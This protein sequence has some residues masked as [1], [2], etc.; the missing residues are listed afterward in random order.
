M[1]SPTV[2]A[3]ALQTLCGL[4]AGASAPD[5]RIP[6]TLLFNEGWLL[7]LVLAAA[8][9]GCPGL[10]FALQPQARWFSEALLRSAFL[11]RFRGDPLA[12]SST[13]A[14]AVAGHFRFRPDSKAGLSLA[15]SGSQFVVLE[16]KVFSTLSQ[17]TRRAPGFDQAARNVACMAETLSR[18]GKPVPEWTSLAFHVLAPS[19]QIEAGVFAA[20][21]EKASIRSRIAARIAMYEGS[22]RDR[23]ETWFHD[24]VCPVLDQIVISALDW[25]S[26]LQALS[27]HNPDLGRGLEQFY[28][29][30]LR[31]NGRSQETGA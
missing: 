8:E 27:A 13:H 14:D 28:A 12:E 4:L 2:P 31:Y 5:S 22:D 11:P 17:G 15:P 25:E 6:P 3:S 16:A 20:E 7:R 9:T 19:A 21:L 1:E 10:P 29:L 23:R 30:T 24:W 18:A 26:L